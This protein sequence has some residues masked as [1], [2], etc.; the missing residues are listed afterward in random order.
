MLYNSKAYILEDGIVGVMPNDDTCFRQIVLQKSDNIKVLER[1]VSSL[2]KENTK[3]KFIES[4]E[5]SIETNDEFNKKI[6]QLENNTA[7]NIDIME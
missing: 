6:S 1:V 4:S 2:Y 5:K 7:I 3:I